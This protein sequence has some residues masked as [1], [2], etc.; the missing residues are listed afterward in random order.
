MGESRYNTKDIPEAVFFSFSILCFYKGITS[1]SVKWIFFSS[2]FTA[3]AFGTKFNIVFLPLIII[4]WIILYF[5]SELKK[6]EFHKFLKLRIKLILSFLFF[7]IIGILIF[8]VAWPN[9]WIDTIER[10]NY[11][12]NYYKSIGTNSSFDPRFLTFFRF[13]TY[14]IQWI[15]YTTPIVILIPK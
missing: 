3:F 12:I 8:L 15:I 7:P 13:N 5:I 1:N 4:P 2:I 14:A 9:L 10:F 6:L 11:I